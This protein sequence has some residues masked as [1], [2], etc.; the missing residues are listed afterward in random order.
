M[1]YLQAFTLPDADQESA[2]AMEILRKCYNDFYPFQVLPAKGISRV[3]FAPI[4][5]FC[6]GNGSGKSTLLN[7]IAEKLGVRRDSLYNRSSFFEDYLA[8]CEADTCGTVP[9]NSC[10]TTSDD[11]FDFMLNLRAVNQGIDRRREQMFEEYL[12]AKYSQFQMRSMEDY[13]TLRH[14]NETRRKTQSRYVREHL[15]GNV[16]EHSNGESA[17]LYFQDKV[18][19]NGLFLLDEPENSL[20]PQ[21]QRELCRFL[22]EAARFYNCQLI[23]ATHSPFL[24]AM[25]GARIYDMDASPARTVKWTDVP[26]VRAYFDFFKEH[27]GEFGAFFQ[28]I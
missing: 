11:V 19:E 21:K 28:E 17:L 27:Q 6:G 12:E 1:I 20:S 15:G 25:R 16:R 26:N 14:I 3:E 23:I 7:V 4:T 13:Q 24:L 8:L 9:M 2:F 10:I 18:T 5:I 22:E